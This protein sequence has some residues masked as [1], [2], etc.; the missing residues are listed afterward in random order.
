MTL[1]AE[2]HC[3]CTGAPPWPAMVRLRTGGPNRYYLC[4]QCGAV[5]E[6]VYRDSL[7]VERNWHDAA[8]GA[9]SESVR[10]EARH[11]LGMPRGEQLRLWDDG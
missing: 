7:I 2:A 1:T 3:D 8:N 9:L 4:R 6:D 11:I 10:E 5:R